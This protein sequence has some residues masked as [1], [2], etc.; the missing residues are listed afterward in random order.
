MFFLDAN[1]A[2]LNVT[3]G[4]TG[5]F[6]FFYSSSTA[7]TIN[8]YD[9]LNGTGNIVASLNLAA[10]SIIAQAIQRDPSATGLRSA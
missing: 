8:V 3:N 1:N 7:A 6:S 10:Y 4:F 2:I 5:G 9:A